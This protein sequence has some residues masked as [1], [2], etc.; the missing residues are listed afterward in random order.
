MTSRESSSTSFRSGP[1]EAGDFAVDD[2][3]DKGSILQQIKEDGG[4]SRNTQVVRL[5]TDSRSDSMLSTDS[6][7]STDGRLSIDTRLSTQ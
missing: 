7:L 3:N 1:L 4:N 2:K 5:S 6:R